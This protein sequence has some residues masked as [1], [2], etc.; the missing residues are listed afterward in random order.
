M[1]EISKKILAITLASVVSIGG[2]SA[3]AIS[4]AEK[5]NQTVNASNT[6]VSSSATQKTERQRNG[7]GNN[8]QKQKKW[9]FRKSE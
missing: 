8:S 1:R 5:S 6:D 7:G 2:I 4:N 3:F 9:K